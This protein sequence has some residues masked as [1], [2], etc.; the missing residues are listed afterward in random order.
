[1]CLALRHMSNKSMEVWYGALYSDNSYTDSLRPKASQQCSSLA[2]G[3]TLL[4]RKGKAQKF[5]ATFLWILFSEP[6]RIGFLTASR[7]CASLQHQKDSLS[8]KK[9]QSVRIN[10]SRVPQ[11]LDL[12]CRSYTKSTAIVCF[13]IGW[14]RSQRSYLCYVA[15]RE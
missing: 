13:P 8:P 3:H 5:K 12:D 2:K 9:R 11:G 4:E 10:L 15:H 6:W 1:M 7:V 14:G